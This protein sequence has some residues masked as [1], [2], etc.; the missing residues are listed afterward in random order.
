M[1][2]TYGSI[3]SILLPAILLGGCASITLPDYPMR[4]LDEYE[5]KQIKESFA[6]AIQPLTREDVEKYFGTNLLAENIFPVFVVMENRSSESSYVFLKDRI[7]LIAGQIPPERK[8][9]QERLMIDRN[10][11]TV[12]GAALL[13]SFGQ[14]GFAPLVLAALP[15]AIIG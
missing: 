13:S 11:D 15:L 9:V 6:L 10:A 4:P 2:R 12:M 7:R 1:N 14:I 5:R 8:S 3:L